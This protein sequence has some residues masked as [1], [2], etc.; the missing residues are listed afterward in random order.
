L[1]TE[2]KIMFKKLLAIMLTV[3]VAFSLVGCG[4]DEGKIKLA[5][6][7]GVVVYKDDIKVTDADVKSAIDNALSQSAKE[8]KVKKG[9]VGASDKVNVDYKGQIEYK[10]KKE[11]F[12]GGT[13][14]KQDIDLAQDAQNYIEGFTSSI[15]GHNVGDKFT[16]K[17]KFP[18]TYTNKAKVK[19]K[20]VS[21]A[22]KPVWF[23]FKINSLTKK[24]TPKLND[25]FVKENAKTL[26]QADK[27]IKTVKELKKYIKT[28]MRKYNISNKIMGKILENSKV[29]KYSDKELKKAKKKLTDQQLAQ[30]SQQFGGEVSLDAYLKACQMSKKQW[31][32]QL[33]EQAKQVVKQN[34]FIREVAKRENLTLSAKEYKKEASKYAKQNGMTLKDFEKQQGKDE[35][36]IGIL[37]QKVQDF[38]VDNV[39]EKKGSEPTTTPAPMTTKKAKTKKK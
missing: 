4:S 37:A 10:G 33:T 22:G 34:M 25:K 13:A 39:K 3:A 38:I 14:E 15:V 17:M 27:D 19:G 23:T 28:E 1:K 20:E 21:L 8:K 16:A 2:V 11:A 29:T 35:I 31:N 12:E 6:Y 5:K 36:E 7:K 18:K 32:K 24:D 30:Y 9:K 26:F